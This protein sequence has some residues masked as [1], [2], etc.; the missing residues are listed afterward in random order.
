[1]DRPELHA[2]AVWLVLLCA[3]HS[4]CVGYC[5]LPLLALCSGDSSGVLRALHELQYW[6]RLAATRDRLCP[7]L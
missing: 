7:L 6:L 2:M 5:M 4:R 3:H 1:M